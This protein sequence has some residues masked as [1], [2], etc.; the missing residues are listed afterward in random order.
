MGRGEIMTNKEILKL[1]DRLRDHADQSIE[2]CNEI[3][4]KLDNKEPDKDWPDTFE[5]AMK[6]SEYWGFEVSGSRY[7]IVCNGPA[8]RYAVNLIGTWAPK[9]SMKMYWNKTNDEFIY[10]FHKFDSG[11]ELYR[12]LLEGETE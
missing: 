10:S 8:Y 11:A 2:L 1:A 5:E 7:M 3:T 4:E 9:G 6:E 12:W